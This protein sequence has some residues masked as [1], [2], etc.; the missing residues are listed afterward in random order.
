M[1]MEVHRTRGFDP[2]LG[3]VTL[4]LVALGLLMVYSA[5]GVA[6][7]EKFSNSLAF[8]AQQA[9]GAAAGIGLVLVLLRVRKPFY[10]QSGFVIGL[11]V[12][13]TVL[14]GL[15]FLMPSIARTNRWIIVPGLRFQP[16]ELAKIS[17]I[18]FLAWHLER[19]Q[20]RVKEIKPLLAPLAVVV[21]VVLLILREP[22]FGTAVLVFG[23]SMI[24]FFLAGAP[25]RFFAIPAGF[26][27][28]VFA[29]YL[30]SSDYRLDRLLA[31]LSPEKNLQTLNFQ[32]L[33]SK[34]AIGSGGL[35]G[36]SLGESVQKLYFLPC[37]HTDFI[38]SI[39]GEEFGFLGTVG[40]IA[41]FSVLVWRGLKVSFKAPNLF[42]QLAA[43]GLTFLIGV[44]ALLNIS[45]V[46][47]LGPA[48]GVPLP[49]LSFGRSS[50][51]MSLLA[52]G[53]LLHISQRRA[54]P[55]GKR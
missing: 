54:I 28:P 16:S 9:V 3:G 20:D 24:I 47:G 36:V 5:S 45:V 44:Q 43:A 23:L 14:L 55:Q 12:L 34:L 41:L 38:F 33:Q 1:S 32:I 39:I 7:A 27:L 18:L 2:A 15:C 30:F 11:L 40:T 26:G 10:Q 17:L 46:L 25:V 48:K 21:L 49:F 4:T 13:T 50:L 37:A 42:S 19:I 35:L 52:V 22:D 31:F 51:M 53:L 6:A 29:Y 8:Y